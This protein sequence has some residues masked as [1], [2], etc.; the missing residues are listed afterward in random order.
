MDLS[1]YSPADRPHYER[2]NSDESV[3]FTGEV[4]KCF[5]FH[6]I[7]IST[8]LGADSVMRQKEIL[9]MCYVLLSLFVKARL[10]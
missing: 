2:T 4:P 10:K 1:S 5:R 7:S 8:A 6:A 9:R 3:P